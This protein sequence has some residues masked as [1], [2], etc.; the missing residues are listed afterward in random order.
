MEHLLDLDVC[1]PVG[2]IALVVLGWLFSLTPEGKRQREI[3]NQKALE[4]DRRVDET[5][6]PPRRY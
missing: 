2:A 4:R 1:I 6:G 3:N 5:Y